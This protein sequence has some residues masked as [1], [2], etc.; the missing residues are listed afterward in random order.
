[1]QL[2][3][4]RKEKYQE[5]QFNT[6]KILS[7]TV[8][9]AG[10]I[11]LNQHTKQ[12]PSFLRNSI[13]P[14]QLTETWT[15]NKNGSLDRIVY[16]GHADYAITWHTLPGFPNICY[17]WLNKVIPTFT[18]YFVPESQQ[19]IDAAEIDRYEPGDCCSK[20]PREIEVYSL[21]GACGKHYQREFDR[22][23]KEQSQ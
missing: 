19:E 13:E 23:M 4:N 7:A 11:Y 16:E 21:T 12:H 1:M 15:A 6:F 8:V 5:R 18:R 10:I 22:T 9:C 17:P 3:E 20:R 2:K 14:G